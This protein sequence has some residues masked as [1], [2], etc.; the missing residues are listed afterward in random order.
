MAQS[1]DE[2]KSN[3]FEGLVETDPSLLLKAALGATGAQT[4]IVKTIGAIA[5]VTALAA[6][7]GSLYGIG[8]ISTVRDALEAE[9]KVE[10]PAISS[11]YAGNTNL[12][13]LP[14]TINNLAQP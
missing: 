14:P 13:A 1:N 8:V 12:N 4:S 10:E 7:A 6:A 3:E 2:A 11:R 9:S 5:L